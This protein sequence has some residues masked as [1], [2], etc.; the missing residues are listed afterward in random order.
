[1][2]RKLLFCG[3]AL[4][5]LTSLAFG[6]DINNLNFSISMDCGRTR[7]CEA[8]GGNAGSPASA[9]A[10]FNYIG[11]PFTFST[12]T[13]DA[14]E[15]TFNGDNYYATFGYGGTFRMTGPGGLT[16]T[17]VVTS[18][19]SYEVEGG[20]W[21]LEVSY[22]GQWSNGVYANGFAQ[23]AVADDGN[24]GTAALQSQ[25]SPEPSSLLLMGTGVVGV[26]LRKR[27]W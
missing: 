8:N 10:D 13:G 25:V 9:A 11:L 15:W 20:S 12:Y 16:F 3:I 17:A 1:M 18:G 4:L 23:V 22:T 21:G 14:T 19:S 27:F 5:C 2:S 6:D 24:Y 7:Y 26:V